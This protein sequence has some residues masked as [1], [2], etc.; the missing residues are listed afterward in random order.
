MKKKIAAIGLAI[1]LSFAGAGIAGASA[2]PAEKRCEEAKAALVSLQEKANRET[3]LV[4]KEILLKMIAGAAPAVESQCN[5]PS[6]R[7]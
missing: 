5:P 7:Y 1:G 2:T 6:R 3:N 4:R